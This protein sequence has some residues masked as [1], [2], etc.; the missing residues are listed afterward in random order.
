MVAET[1]AR[2]IAGV[3]WPPPWPPACSPLD[4]CVLIARTRIEGVPLVEVAQALGRPY[5][6]V[7][8]ERRRAE[9]ALRTFVRRYESEEGS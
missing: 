7:R 4:T 8:M 1:V 6:A 5:D 3:C 9:A 2:G